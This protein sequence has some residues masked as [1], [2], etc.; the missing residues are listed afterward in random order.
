M[1]SIRQQLE[2]LQ[3]LDSKEVEEEV[4]EVTDI[5][6]QE[7]VDEEVAADDK[8]NGTLDVPQDPSVA[9][10]EPAE[11]VTP[12]QSTPE[13]PPAPEEPEGLDQE[14]TVEPDSSEPV[15]LAGEPDVPSSGAA[16]PSP[17][18][19]LT[20]ED[21]D[22]APLA[23]QDLDPEE[24]VSQPPE[25]SVPRQ[26]ADF[27]LPQ[28]VEDSAGL[29]DSTMPDDPVSVVEYQGAPDIPI[30]P[31]PEDVFREMDSR[32]QEGEDLATKL[33]RELN[34][35]FDAMQVYQEQV[36]HDSINDNILRT[37][38]LGRIY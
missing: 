3:S 7:E 13:L 17:L 32:R 37:T 28:D 20:S 18:P 5:L 11:A 16:E 24:E 10:D 12:E 38:L 9:V 29:D 2:E 23:P 34:P 31:R 26:D 33:A 19:T 22:P 8:E 25:P 35:K 27:G 6:E 1:K 36:V 30:P 4:E 15:Q 21:D 14:P